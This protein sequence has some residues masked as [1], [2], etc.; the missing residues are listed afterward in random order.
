[1]RVGELFC[2]MAEA[3]VL[4]EQLRICFNTLCTHQ[5]IGTTPPA[6]G[7]WLLKTKDQ[8]GKGITPKFVS[9]DSTPQEVSQRLNL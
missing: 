4:L 5:S 6:P 3:W 8:R 7:T 9:S 2:S 1:M